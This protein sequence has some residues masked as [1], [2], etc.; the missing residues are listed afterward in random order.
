MVLW[1]VKSMCNIDIIYK[2]QVNI[3]IIVKNYVVVNI[4]RILLLNFYKMNPRLFVLKYINITRF[5][6]PFSYLDT[7][8]ILIALISLSW[9]GFIN[10]ERLMTCQ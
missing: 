6:N 7:T 9:L 10:K 4:S 8:Y 1:G 3:R 5:I 2:E